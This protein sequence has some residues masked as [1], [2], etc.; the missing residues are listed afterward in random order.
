MQEHEREQARG[1]GVVGHQRREEP[2][3]ADGLVAELR[4]HEAV[5]VARGVAL[6]EHEV[7]DGEDAGEAVGQRVVGRDAVGDRGLRDLALG[8]DEALGHRRLG[9]EERARDLGRRQAAE[10]A[11]RQGDARLDRERRVTAREDEPQPVVR[12]GALLRGVRLGLLLEVHED[13]EGLD[14]VGEHALA[15]D[16]VDRPA[17]RGHG[18]PR[19]GVRRRAGAG[20]GPQRVGERVLQ[21]V[22]GQREVSADVADQRGED[23]P[24]LLAEGALDRARAHIPG[25]SMTGRT[26][27]APW[28]AAGIRAAC[29]VAVSRS[30][31]S[32]T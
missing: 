10:R 21:R 14:A 2:A 3:E 26:S 23:A 6:V 22:L 18:D 32:S 13:L 27:M 9:H 25:I 20:P 28:R 4:A 30:G 19:A 16:P 11:Q 31:Q 8:A 24:G 7:D 29:A 17:A 1:L 15:A 5:V 12:D